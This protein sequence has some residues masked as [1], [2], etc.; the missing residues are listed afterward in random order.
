MRL[1]Q[2]TVLSW[3]GRA[4]SAEADANDRS[5]GRAS[6]V[7]STVSPKCPEK[8][9]CILVSRP[10]FFDGLLQPAPLLD[11]AVARVA[12]HDMVHQVDTHHHAGRRQPPRQLVILRAR[13]RISRRM[14][15]DNQDRSRDCSLY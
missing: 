12:E 14:V 15:V 11:A 6:M 13:R 1:V 2:P 8:R 9:S 4:L 5:R 10:V 3:Y 7:P